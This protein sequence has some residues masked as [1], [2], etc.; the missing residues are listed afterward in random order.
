[1]G[2][3]WGGAARKILC[4]RGADDDAIHGVWALRVRE[5][6]QAEIADAEFFFTP[7]SGLCARHERRRARPSRIFVK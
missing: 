4:V 6:P 5:P 3:G 7:R 2:A 1:M